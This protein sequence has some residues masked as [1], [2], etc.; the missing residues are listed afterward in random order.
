VNVLVVNSGSSSLKLRLIDAADDLVAAADLPRLEES[1]L[2]DA[3]GNFLEQ[4]PVVDAAGHRIV[5]GGSAFRQPILLD[6]ENDAALEALADLAPLHNPP[7]LAAVEAL[8]SLRPHLDQVACFDTTFHADMPAKATTYAV[9]NSWRDRWDLRR[10]GFHGLSHDW[11]SR[12]AGELLGPGREQ[13]RLVTAHIGAGASLA[14]VAFGHSVDTTMGFT[15]MEGLVMA[16]RS[17][18][19][20]P[21]L[22]LWVQRHG[23]LS[24]D[25]VEAALEHDSGLRGLFGGSGDLRSVVAAAESGDQ[26]ARLAY[27]VYVYRIQTNVAAMCAGMEGLDGL[28]FTGGAG[29]G[30]PSLRS[31][32]CAGLGFLGLSVDRSRN[33]SLKGDGLVSANGS[34]ASVLVVEA[35][36]DLE[37]ARHVRERLT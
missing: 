8:R 13:L 6:A 14:A 26:A 34:S 31:D 18:S 36:E 25:D 23:D 27:E 30:S 4:N 24:A 37:I 21:G 9:P 32:V 19:V 5:H 29:E 3:L 7:G 1:E 16:T 15:P 11:S 35:R 2:S 33:E 12:R 28:V 10:F 17:G 20:D 22:I